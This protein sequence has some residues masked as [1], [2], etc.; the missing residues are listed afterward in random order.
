ML[1]WIVTAIGIC[2]VYS[3]LI[4]R[5]WLDVRQV[6]AAIPQLPA[7]FTGF[8]IAL[9]SDI[10]LGFFYQP[11]QLARL[12]RRINRLRPDIVCFTGDLLDSPAGFQV[13][14]SAVR[15]LSK[16]NAPYGKL[17]VIGNHDHYSGVKKIIQGLQQGGFT[18]LQNDHVVLKKD[19]D[20]LY[21]LGLDDVLDGKPNL[22]QVMNGVP[23][24][25][26]KILLVH[27]P[28]YAATALAAPIAL[29]L[30]GH[31]HG[32]QV[33]LPFIGAILTTKLGKQF[34]AGLNRGKNWLV[35]TTRGIGTTHLPIRFCCRPE[36]TMMTLSSADT[37]N[38]IF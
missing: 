36:L 6:N 21:F 18:V 11:K 32:G 15:E 29:Q 20:R 7:S 13:L 28:D 12:I 9:F 35:Y 34:S 19:G 1:E 30:S 16:L 26:C 37:M 10:H 25:D 24:S 3:V 22:H 14:A 31:S 38:N 5:H 17:A 23:P 27:E 8:K 33:R 2:G 4:E